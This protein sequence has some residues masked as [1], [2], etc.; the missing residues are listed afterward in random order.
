MESQSLVEL[1]HAG[2]RHGAKSVTD[3]LDRDG[4]NL[5]SL[6]LRIAIQA[7]LV[8]RNQ[9]RTV[10]QVVEAG[11]SRQV[12]FKATSRFNLKANKPTPEIEDAVVKSVAK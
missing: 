8:I 4:P 12:E 1:K 10:T 3:T 7:A 5:L 2:R 6:G 9:Y 11:E